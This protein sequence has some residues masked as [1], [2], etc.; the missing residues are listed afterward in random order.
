VAQWRA[1][2]AKRSVA[3]PAEASRGSREAEFLPAAVPTATCAWRIAILSDLARK[4]Q[5]CERSDSR[6]CSPA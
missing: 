4:V 6:S 3:E 1:L 2:T 5:S